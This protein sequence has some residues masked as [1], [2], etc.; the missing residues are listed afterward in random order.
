M[1]IFNPKLWTKEEIQGVRDDTLVELDNRYINVGE[2]VLD[3]NINNLNLINLNIASSGRIYFNGDNT[4]QTT[5]YNPNLITNKINELKNQTNTF[6]GT[7]NFI[8]L[9]ITDT[10][11]NQTEIRQNSNYLKIE[12]KAITGFIEFITSASGTKKTVTIDMFGNF[13]GIND[14]NS[15]RIKTKEIF[16]NNLIS[17]SESGG[18]LL[19][20]N[21]INNGAYVWKTKTLTG[22][23]GWQMVYDSRGHLYG[24]NNVITHILETKYLNFRDS[25]TYQLTGSQIYQSGRDIIIENGIRPGSFK[26]KHKTS[27]NNENILL[28]N[29]FMNMSGVND[30]DMKGKLTINNNSV[31]HRYDSNIY[32]INNKNPGSSIQIRNYDSTG[33]LRQINMDQYMNMSGVNDLYVQRIFFN[34]VLFNP[35]DVNILNNKCTQLSYINSPEQTRITKTSTGKGILFVPDALDGIYNNIVRMEDSVIAFLG[36]S[37]DSNGAL[38][39]TNWSSTT[40]GIRIK[41]NETE[42]YKPKVMDSL[43]FQDNSVQTTAMTETYLT[44]LIQSVVNQMT[45]IPQIPIGAII[46]Y[47]ANYADAT[48]FSYPPPAGYLWCI[49][50]MVAIEAYQNLFNV[51]GHNFLHGK[52]VYGG[53]FYLPELQGS[54]LKGCGGSTLFSKQKIMQYVGYHQEGNVGGHAHTYKDRGSGSY[55]IAGQN[56]SPGTSTTIANDT[57]GMFWTD[58]KAYNSETR[59]ELDAENRPNSIGVNYIIKF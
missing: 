22:T 51:I 48:T 25:T 47:G 26:L 27:D 11:G 59:M 52:S 24:M 56:P 23:D 49:G 9:N 10:S 8:N 7:N 13:Y 35:N 42:L 12:N 53:F 40:S 5:A 36:S 15:I 33:V 16:L 39:L 41:S 46:P 30:I 37:P 32:L 44:N 3:Q 18:N 54:Y 55:S 50:E 20:Q 38:T 14:L 2:N 1:S 19:F 29:E 17:L 21:N 31:E 34:N 57:D 4:I 45:I 58:G 28:I 43:K 6:T